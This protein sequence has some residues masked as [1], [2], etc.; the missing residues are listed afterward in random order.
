MPSS[1]APAFT[2]DA[3]QPSFPITSTSEYRLGSIYRPEVRDR[4]LNPIKRV[5]RAEGEA[6]GSLRI[7]EPVFKS[8]MLAP[9]TMNDPGNIAIVKDAFD[10]YFGDDSVPLDP[11]GP[12]EDCSVLS[13][14]CGKPLVFTLYGCVDPEQW[15]KAVKE[16]RVDE[17]PQY[18]SAFFCTRYPAD[19][20]DGSRCV[21]RFSSGLPSKM[22]VRREMS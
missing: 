5:V 13:T 20:A 4:V 14:A 22:R 7:E 10:Q 3:L 16:G 12:S 11:L 18:H 17:I 21:C 15:A 2:E 9:P 19:V 6:S 8:I 1:G